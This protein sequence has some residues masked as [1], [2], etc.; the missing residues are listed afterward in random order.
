MLLY[1]TVKQIFRNAPAYVEMCEDNIR[2]ANEIFQ[3]LFPSIVKKRKLSAATEILSDGP[4]RSD[5]DISPAASHL[6]SQIDAIVMPK[7][8]NKEIGLEVADVRSAVDFSAIEW[9]DGDSVE[10]SYA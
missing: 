3:L 9:E 2:S 7:E 5:C 10:V 1:Q 4:R 8:C 6:A